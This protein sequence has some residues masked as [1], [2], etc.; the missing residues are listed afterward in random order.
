MKK[1]HQMHKSL[2]NYCRFIEDRSE[3]DLPSSSLPEE[4]RIKT[5]QIETLKLSDSL[6]VAMSWSKDTIASSHRTSDNF[7]LPPT[8]PTPS[9]LHTEGQNARSATGCEPSWYHRW[10]WSNPSNPCG[11]FDIATDETARLIPPPYLVNF[12][13]S[14]DSNQNYRTCR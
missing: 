8:P 7:E 6:F 2:K 1:K 5:S 3:L 4:A 13:Q 10:S 9:S 12:L 14:T 11:G